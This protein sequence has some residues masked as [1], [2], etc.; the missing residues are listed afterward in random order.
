MTMCP[1]T[2]HGTAMIAILAAPLGEIMV[3]DANRSIVTDFTAMVTFTE[4]CL[5]SAIKARF[6]AAKYGAVYNC[7]VSELSE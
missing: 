4:M 2:V 7:V 3:A 5:I 1:M 6:R